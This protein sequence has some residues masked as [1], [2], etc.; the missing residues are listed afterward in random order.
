MD[1]MVTNVYLMFN[2]DRLCI[3]KALGKRKQRKQEKSKNNVG[4]AWG[5]FWFHQLAWRYIGL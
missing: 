2:Y 5:P 3:D 1:N 4:S